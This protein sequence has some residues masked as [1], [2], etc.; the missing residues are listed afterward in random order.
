MFR[1]RSV[2]CSLFAFLICCRR[3]C[4]SPGI[5]SIRAVSKRASNRTKLPDSPNMANVVSD[6]SHTSAHLKASV[7]KEVAEDMESRAWS[8]QRSKPVPGLG[9]DMSLTESASRGFEYCTANPVLPVAGVTT[10]ASPRF[11]GRPASV[12]MPGGCRT[13]LR[14]YPEANEACRGVGGVVTASLSAFPHDEPSLG[15]AFVASSI[16]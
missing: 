10:V 1:S 2:R 13:G 11:T 9:N 8:H 4:V 14:G 6:F 5:H 7:Q 3:R 12:P 15:Q 16:A